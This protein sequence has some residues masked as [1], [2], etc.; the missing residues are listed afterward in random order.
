VL[1]PDDLMAGA[2]PTG[3]V[4]VFDDDHYYMGPVLAAL[5]ARS[6]AR[7]TYVTTEARAG[8]WSHYTGEQEA[9]QRQLLE[10]GVEIIVDTCLAA[11]EGTYVFLECIYTATVRKHTANALVLVTSREPDDTLY[12]ELVPDGE[13]HAGNI[14]RIGDCLQPAL[15][16]HAVYCGHKAAR[17][18]DEGP[19]HQPPQR[20]RVVI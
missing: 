2:R 10:L 8:A 15:I 5:L 1:T 13:E 18:L 3:A 11:F 16:A 14:Q 6:G 7:V 20:D 12:R 19:E 17:E 4:T 9:T